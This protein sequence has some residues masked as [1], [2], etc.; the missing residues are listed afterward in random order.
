MARS[1]PTRSITV[2]SQPQ[3]RA[4]KAAASSKG[5]ITRAKP[6]SLL[7]TKA[8]STKRK[9]TEQCSSSP[10]HLSAADERALAILKKRKSDAARKAEQARQL[11]IHEAAAAMADADS[12]ED[13]EESQGEED[14]PQVD[15]RSTDEEDEVIFRGTPVPLT[16]PRQQ[17][18]DEESD[19]DAAFF[20]NTF[21]TGNLHGHDSDEEHQMLAGN[22]FEKGDTTDS[23]NIDEP[24]NNICVS[25][26]P[27]P[28]T[29]SKK[30]TASQCLRQRLALNISP[31]H[32]KSSGV[33][34]PAATRRRRSSKITNDHF[35]PRTL[36][37]ALAGKK[38]AHCETTTVD[39]FPGDK[40]KFFLGILHKLATTEKDGPLYQAYGRVLANMDLQKDLVLFLGYAR[41][42]I[43]T[44]FIS[45]A[46]QWVPSRF[47]L[48]GTMAAVEV[49]DLVQW[50][51]HDGRF[52]YG[53]ID[54]V[55]RTYN[56]KLPFGSEGIAHILQLEVFASKG[57]ANID[58]FREVVAAG[59]IRGPTI[60]L[61]LTCIEHA[62]NEY[63]D[64]V[65]RHAEFSDAAR[66]RYLF[67]LSSYNKIA[68]A[69]PTWAENFEISL[70]K[71]IITQSN[72]AFLLDVQADDLNEVD[73]AGLE[74]DVVA[75]KDLVSV[76]SFAVGE[77]SAASITATAPGPPIA[78]TASP[79]TI[80]T[81][82]APTASLASATHAAT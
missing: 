78:A 60:A 73:V 39:A 7:K 8:P 79:T 63:S 42:G 37:L 74:A 11:A 52:K 10:I 68:V 20:A 80:T 51:A 65:H 5:P 69:A 19:E 43:F 2:A 30:M 82:P 17:Q 27:V 56:T 67:H 33:G 77:S 26:S 71:L 6:P 29:P 13:E 22:L 1:G 58:V 66:S 16:S 24:N 76:G 61:M 4:A 64:G 70:Y 9:N 25:S 31:S 49:R 3:T 15:Q 12:K 81:V 48:P 36:S 14:Q 41:G 21:G 44:G 40:H 23:M 18:D 32:S 59:R 54:P 45:H 46:R 72:K 55:N 53:E 62:L 28:S 38:S 50:I 75:E 34:S 35:T 47:G 57:G